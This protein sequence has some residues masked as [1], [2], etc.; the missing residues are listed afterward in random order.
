MYHILKSYEG[1]FIIYEMGGAANKG[2]EEKGTY[3]SGGGAK[4]KMR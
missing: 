4:K 3:F 2:G 1:H